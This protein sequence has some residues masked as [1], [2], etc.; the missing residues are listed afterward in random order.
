MMIV[1][2]VILSTNLVLA[3]RENLPA[4]VVVSCSMSKTNTFCRRSWLLV[5]VWT[6]DSFTEFVFSGDAIM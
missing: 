2:E 3:M 6:S 4:R 5:L 1:S